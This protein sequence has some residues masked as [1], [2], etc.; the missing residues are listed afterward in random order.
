ME[1]IIS[2]ELTITCLQNKI[3]E[4]E[5]YNMSGELTF[6]AKCDSNEVKVPSLEKKK[7]LIKITT[8]EGKVCTKKV[9]L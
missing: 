4:V 8:C 9:S 1:D 7:H 6:S 3:K 2:H 5:V